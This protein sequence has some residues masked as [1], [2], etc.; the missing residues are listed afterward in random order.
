MSRKDWP[1]DVKRKVLLE[2]MKETPRQLLYKELWCAS[3]G[4]TAF[5]AKLQRYA[6]Q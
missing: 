5:N 4:L 6:D 2:L 3:D 1:H